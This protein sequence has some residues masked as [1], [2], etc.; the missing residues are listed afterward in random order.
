M[1]LDTAAVLALRLRFVVR[2]GGL[3]RARATDL[4]AEV[5]R[6]R[7]ERPGDSAYGDAIEDVAEARRAILHLNGELPRKHLVGGRW[8]AR[9][10]GNFGGE[11][12][13]RAGGDGDSEIVLAHGVCSR[14]K[15]ES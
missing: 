15:A 6:V 1:D 13:R 7:R 10:E 14:L 9:G 11:V 3:A 2:A 12:N 4:Q 8:G 5:V